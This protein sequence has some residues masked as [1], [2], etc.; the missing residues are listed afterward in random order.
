[1]LHAAKMWYVV[2]PCV[3][4]IGL[5]HTEVSILSY[6]LRAYINTS[7]EIQPVYISFMYVFSQNILHQR[8]STVYSLLKVI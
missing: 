5:Q 1:M 4:G 3:C 8:I 6:C 2:W 7:L